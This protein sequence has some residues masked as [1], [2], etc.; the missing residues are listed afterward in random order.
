MAPSTQLIALSSGISG[1]SVISP[2]FR[3]A[4]QFTSSLSL[5]YYPRKKSYPSTSHLIFYPLNYRALAALGVPLPQLPSLFFSAA[6]I[7]A[8]LTFNLVSCDRP[9]FPLLTGSA[10]S[11]C[12]ASPVAQ[13]NPSSYQEKKLSPILRMIDGRSPNHVWTK[14]QKT[15]SQRRQ[16][17][18]RT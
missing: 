1:A 11:H 2:K 16:S 5:P 13:K 8:A 12:D 7:E 15:G 3:V 4:Q 10:G 18:T 6:C 17:R 9:H 14:H